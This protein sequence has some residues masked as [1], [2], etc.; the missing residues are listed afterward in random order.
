MVSTRSRTGRTVG[1]KHAQAD[2]ND[3]TPKRQAIVEHASDANTHPVCA[4][5][6]SPPPRGF[7][8]V[9]ID[10]EMIDGCKGDRKKL[11]ELCTAANTC[12][13]WR[14]R[15]RLLHQAIIEEWGN[16][17]ICAILAHFPGEG[18]RHLLY[19]PSY[20]KVARTTALC[21]ATTC[22]F[23]Y[24]VFKKFPGET[25]DR[26]LNVSK[27]MSINGHFLFSR[28]VWGM[29]T[30]TNIMNARRVI[31]DA[32]WE[33]KYYLWAQPD[34]FMDLIINMRP[35]LTMTTTTSLLT[36]FHYYSTRDLPLGQRWQTT[37][38]LSVQQILSQ[39]RPD[40]LLHQLVTSGG[41]SYIC[42]IMGFEEAHAAMSAEQRAHV[43]DEMTGLEKLEDAWRW[44]KNMIAPLPSTMREEFNAAI[45]RMRALEAS[46]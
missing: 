11:L 20:V 34:W 42:N 4:P 35:G 1:T 28:A 21:A 41:N 30:L 38:P 22:D 24:A 19:D 14:Y 10:K 26:V 8:T 36:P 15:K 40:D 9:V 33:I 46:A 7:T 27:E 5:D 16:E 25:L 43:V 32:Y 45:E 37:Q 17:L 23:W 2:A 6:P 29:L 18:A 12:V 44:R 3:D 39:D 31:L 13:D